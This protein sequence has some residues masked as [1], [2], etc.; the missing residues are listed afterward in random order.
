MPFFVASLIGWQCVANR[1]FVVGNLL[2]HI[3][4]IPWEAVSLFGIGCYVCE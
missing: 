4:E 2:V 1:I 3:L